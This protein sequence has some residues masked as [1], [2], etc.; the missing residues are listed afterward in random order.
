MKICVQLVYNVQK[1]SRRAH[2]QEL[3]V[4]TR[5]NSQS[6][7]PEKDISEGQS[8]REKSVHKKK[9]ATENANNGDS[10]SLSDLHKCIVSMGLKLDDGFADIKTSLSNLTEKVESI[11]MEVENIKADQASDREIIGDLR[12]EVKDLRAS[13]LH[14]QVYSRKYH[15][16]VYGLQGHETDPKDTIDKVRTFAKNNLKMDESVANSLR[17]RH[18]HRLQ[19]RENGPAPIIIHFLYWS[20]RES[21]LRAGPNLRQTNMS[22]RSDLPPEL[23]KKRGEL[24]REAYEIRQN[25]QQARLREKGADL[26]IETRATATVR[27]QRHT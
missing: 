10:V 4:V 26:W 7:A 13:L 14:T 27:W 3:S 12:E 11:K 9:M 2:K 18:A 23:K 19:R 8:V 5:S 17:I 6:R 15:L 16:L 25:G 20:E 1:E 21:F 24:A 22:V